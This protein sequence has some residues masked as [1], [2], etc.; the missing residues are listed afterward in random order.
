MS[1]QYSNEPEPDSIKREVIKES[2]LKS[3]NTDKIQLFYGGV[4]DFL[5][6]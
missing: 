1:S 5:T 3:L 4:F 2:F 6:K